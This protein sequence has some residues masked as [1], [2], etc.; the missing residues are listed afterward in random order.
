MPGRFHINPETGLPNICEDGEHCEFGS[1]DFHYASKH[2]AQV[3][4]KARQLERGIIAY[5]TVMQAKE[6]QEEDAALEKLVGRAKSTSKKFSWSIVRSVVTRNLSKY[7]INFLGV[8]MAYA[9]ASGKWL[10]EDWV[11]RLLPIVATIVLISLLGWFLLKAW[12]GSR[13]AARV[14]KKR[15]IRKATRKVPTARPR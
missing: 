1:D 13:K 6:K 11:R 5:R 12:K 4:W 3:A 8:F 7:L 9:V 10:S 2:D 15:R 14:V